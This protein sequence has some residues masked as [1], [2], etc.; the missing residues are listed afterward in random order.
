[1]TDPNSI[2]VTVCAETN[3]DSAP[4]GD[5]TQHSPVAAASYKL[6]VPIPEQTTTKYGNINAV[7]LLRTPCSIAADRNGSV[8]ITTILNAP[9]DLSLVDVAAGDEELSPLESL[10]TTARER[11]ASIVE[12]VASIYP[13]VSVHGSVVVG[14]LIENV[15]E[16]LTATDRYSGLFIP[17]SEDTETT[18]WDRSIIDEIVDTASCAVYIENLGEYSDIQRPEDSSGEE[19]TGENRASSNGTSDILL[20][21]GTGTHSVLGA[22]TARAIARHSGARVHALHLYSTTTERQVKAGGVDA[23]SVCEYVLSDVPNVT[24]TSRE[25]EHVVDDLLAEIEQ[26]DVAV[27]GSPTEQPLLDRLFATSRRG[28]PTAES[29]VSIIMVRQPND[30]MNTVYYRWKRAIERTIEDESSDSPTEESN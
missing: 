7:R 9:S 17:R 30:A 26:Y 12:D 4:V 22:E 1:M 5:R 24:C 21:V 2:P 27:M 3:R 14:H 25:V 15:V 11:I 29:S 13:S 19:F 6:L 8:T 16:Q 23:L 28:E 18:L 10:I 20:A